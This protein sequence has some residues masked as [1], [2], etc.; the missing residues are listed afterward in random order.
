[1]SNDILAL[2]S[3][4]PLYFTFSAIELRIDRYFYGRGFD[5]IQGELGGEG[6]KKKTKKEKKTNK[7]LL[8]IASKSFF[9]VQLGA[10]GKI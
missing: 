10:C 8:L 2:V 6:I 1:M 3:F 9:L 4:F 5:D 7:I